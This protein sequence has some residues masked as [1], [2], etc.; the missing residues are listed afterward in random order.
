MRHFGRTCALIA[1]GLLCVAA[2]KKG[3]GVTVRFHTEANAQDGEPF[4]IP[5][6]LQNPPRQAY[7][8]KIPEFS[9]KNIKAVFPFA[10]P[11]GT[12]GCAFK[13]DQHGGMALTLLSTERRGTS[14]AA[15]VN[16][17][18]VLDMLIDQRVTDGIITIQKGLTEQ[19][20]AALRRKF[21]VLGESKK[22]KRPRE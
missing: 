8:Q 2:A 11:D 10:A 22:G 1:L 9:E 19:E 17:R 18:Q 16:G 15:F 21:P 3:S 14:L 7:L 4:T 5:V 12:M 20:I 6:M 13:L